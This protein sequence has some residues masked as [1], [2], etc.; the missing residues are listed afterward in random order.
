MKDEAAC[1]EI[2]AAVW[3]WCIA[4]SCGWWL[5]VVWGAERILNQ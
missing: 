4:A 2:T 3:L 1:T 5:F